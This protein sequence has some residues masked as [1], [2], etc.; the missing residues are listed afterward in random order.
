[1]TKASVRGHLGGAGSNFSRDILEHDAMVAFLQV[2][3]LE[4]GKHTFTRNRWEPWPAAG[5][6]CTGGQTANK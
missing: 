5:L 3:G 2:S 6:S 4:A 1:V